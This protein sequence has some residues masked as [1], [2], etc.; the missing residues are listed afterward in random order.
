[1]KK[2]V[3]VLAVSA[4]LS[5]LG[6]C[7][8]QV[9]HESTATTVVAQNLHSGID[10]ENFDMSVRPQDDFYR[11]VNGTWLANT[12]LPD[13]KTFMG[14]FFTLADESDDAVKEIILQAQKQSAKSGTSA[15]KVGDLYASFLN[16]EKVNA[17]GFTPIKP[18]LD[19]IAKANT[20]D[21]IAAVMGQLAVYGVTTPIGLAI[22]ADAKNADVNVLYMGQAGLGLPDRDYYLNDDEQSAQLRAAYQHMLTT[23]LQL[24]G[25]SAPEKMAN[26][27]I[28]V[29]TK[30][31]K[32]MWDRTKARETSL[33]YNPV[34]PEELKQK[35]ASFSW[36]EYTKVVDLPEMDKVVIA[37]LS[38]VEDF[39]AL[40]ADISVAQWQAY[41]KFH[42]VNGFASYLSEDFGEAA[43]A[44]FGKVLSGS[45][46]QR[47]RWKRGVSLTNGTL[48]EEIGK[49][50]VEKHFTPE[51]KAKMETLVK[52]L[53]EAYRISIDELEWMSDETKAAAKVK[54]SQFRYK[55]GYPNK[56]RSYDFEIK[57]DDLVGNIMRSA[58]F[59]VKKAI[60]K[61][62]KPV[63]KEEWGMTPQTVNA[64]YHPLR[65]EIVFP[66]AILQPPFFDMNADDAVN[67]GGIGAVIGHELGHGFD[68]Q[69]A[70][71]DGHGNIHNWWQEKDLEQFKSR[72]DALVEQFG[73][74]KLFDDASVNGRLTLGEN[75]GDL[76]GLTVAY[77]AY[78][79]SLEGKPR[80]NLDGYTPEQRFF[81]GFSQI[82]RAKI[83]EQMQRQL[84]QVDTH[85]PGEF[86][87]NGSLTNFTPFYEAFDVK[88]GDKL[89]KPENERIKIW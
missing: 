15:Q 8:Q 37:E 9:K 22:E 55:I 84:L 52:N 24:I 60:A 16:V 42:T 67:Y 68:D 83:R 49:L 38:Y 66:A 56:W 20:H 79:L 28:E 75:I 18:L 85:S 48:G 11:H 30:L 39:G 69:G 26:S 23:Q 51:A 64:Y 31:A 44:F 25:E 6:G 43:F 17:L 12:E 34:T 73:S 35:L 2:T 58:E 4:A 57:P 63:D 87:A 65:N 29:E 19:K 62:G 33:T 45:P 27:I 41:L 76:G 61:I 78:Q 3:L 77:K 21:E 36:S 72:G 7:S 80:Q 82:W 5:V 10:K 54:L 74:Y 46:Q 71:Y 13:D 40:F 14:G 70:Q 53:I 32:I 59:G 81:I 89:Y 50:Y 86:R 88:E 1:M 47:P